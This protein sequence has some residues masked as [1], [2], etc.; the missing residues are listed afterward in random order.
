MG[1]L[2]DIFQDGIVFL[3]EKS[4]FDTDTGDVV[5]D[6][7]KVISQSLAYACSCLRSVCRIW[8]FM[9]DWIPYRSDNCQQRCRHGM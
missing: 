2:M 3:S 5:V 9:E 8:W 1:G 6:V 4:S 7:L